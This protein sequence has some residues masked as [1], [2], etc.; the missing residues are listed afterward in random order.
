M[1]STRTLLILFV[2]LVYTMFSI[3][4]TQTLSFWLN[5]LNSVICHQRRVPYLQC[6]NISI[7]TCNLLQ[8]DLHV[9]I[10]DFL[11]TVRAGNFDHSEKSSD[12]KTQPSKDNSV[13]FRHS[14]SMS[15]VIIELCPP[16]PI[17]PIDTEPWL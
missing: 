11:S 1:M 6:V 17:C 15:N 2:D 12:R 9:S 4:S 7:G 16:L 3:I 13:S 8:T 10:G 5:C 14:L